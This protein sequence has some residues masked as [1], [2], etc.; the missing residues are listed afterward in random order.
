MARVLIA[1][2]ADD[3]DGARDRDRKT[4]VVDDAPGRRDQPVLFEPGDG[5][6]Q[7][8]RSGP[9]AAIAGADDRRGAR[10]RDRVPELGERHRAGGVE[11]E[12]LVAGAGV[13]EVRGSGAAGVVVVV[14]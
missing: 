7:V 8:R 1:G 4:E 5:A 12:Q 2:L 3:G 10:D 6:E 9:A 13:E 14:G 11:L